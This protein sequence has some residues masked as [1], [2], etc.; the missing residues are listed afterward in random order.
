MQPTTKNLEPGRRFSDVELAPCL[1]H[2]QTKDANCKPLPA[3]SGITTMPI[4]RTCWTSAARCKRKLGLPVA[5]DLPF[6]ERL[7]RIR[8]AMVTVIERADPV[9]AMRL[10]NDSEV[11]VNRIHSDG[12]RARQS[13]GELNQACKRCGWYCC[14]RSRNARRIPS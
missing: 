11:A 7:E 6:N 2:Q 14:T 1:D 12:C 13:E 5:P 9:S 3:V 10:Q 4:A 8:T